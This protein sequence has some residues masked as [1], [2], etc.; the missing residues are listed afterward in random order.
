MRPVRIVLQLLRQR[1]KLFAGQRDHLPFAFLRRLSFAIVLI[2]LSITLLLTLVIQG[3]T[4]SYLIRQDE[5]YAQ[6]LAL[7][8]NDVL[9]AQF[10]NL[11]MDPNTTSA[12]S[13]DQLDAS[14]R[15]ILTGLNVR[16]LAIYNQDGQRIYATEPDRTAARDRAP[17]NRA[18]ASALTGHSQSTFA[19][20]VYPDGTTTNNILITYVPIVAPDDTRTPPQVMGA[21][22]IEQDLSA[23]LA[24]LYR[25]QHLL[26]G[27]TIVLMSILL[28][29]LLGM[30]RWAGQVMRTQHT[31]L[32]ERHTA[33]IQLQQTRD[34]LS[35]L[36][37]HDLRSPLTAIGGY[38]DV[39]AL[40]DQDP[41]RRELISTTRGV[42]R[43]MQQLINAILDLQRLQDGSLPLNYQSVH[44]GELLDIT[45]N[46][47]CGWA[48][49]D[50][51][52]IE[53][54][55]APALPPLC[56]DPDL[57]RRILANLLSNAL[58]HT[59][60]GTT[61]ILRAELMQPDSIALSVSDNGPGIPPELRERLF[62]PYVHDGG[63]KE[64]GSS[65]LGLAF[66]RLAVEAHGGTIQVESSSGQGTTFI[67]QLPLQAVGM[68]EAPPENQ[69]SIGVEVERLRG[70]YVHET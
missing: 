16:R 22:A 70:A 63:A 61:V 19:Q 44:V 56:A 27:I 69:P 25:E 55:V 53:L 42:T 6:N 38:L 48:R 59:Y 65:G 62:A 37:V 47:F 32:L 33:L 20:V 46:E 15:H 7:H 30:V 24:Q 60:P 41:Q 64:G 14:V 67:V 2:I 8:L 3:R 17:I 11:V 13:V 29:A 52:Q 39:L 45:A 40:Y 51:K 23:F 35:R 34:E 54:A 66:C 49:R 36:I 50:D 57:L 31:E 5:Q 43:T 26:A 21:F 4:R 58:K 12:T 28:V 68:L 10:A 1:L 9:Y 18:L